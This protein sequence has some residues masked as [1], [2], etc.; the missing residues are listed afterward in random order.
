[1]MRLF[2]S[3]LLFLLL[4]QFSIIG[5]GAEAQP[6]LVNPKFQ[7]ERIFAG[8][9]E[10]SSMAFLGPDDL[11]V[12]DR[13]EGKVFRVTNGTQIGPLL[14]VNVATNGYR[15]LL[16]VDI[17][18]TKNSTYVF[19]Y[20]TES[21]SK[22]SSDKDQPPIE[23]LGNR[24]YR[25]ELVNDKLVNPKLLLDLPVL[26]GPKDN[27]GVLKIGPDNNVYLIIG[28][29]QGSFA[30]EHYETMAQNYQNS[31]HVD[32][33]AGILVVSQ[34]G[35]SMGKGILGSSFP[36][37]LYYA[38]GIRNSFGMDWDPETGYLW[39]SEN[40][41]A[42]GDELNLVFSGFNSGWAQVQGIWKPISQ[43]IGP[44]DSS[45]NLVNFSGRGNYSAPKFIWLT[46]TAPSAIKFINS[47]RYGLDYENDLLV[48]DVNN[49][50]IYHFKLDGRR[51]NLILNGNLS[52]RIANDTSE[53][54]D[55]IFARGFGKVTG[56]EI[57][58]DG[59]LYILSGQKHVTGIYRINAP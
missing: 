2:I 58:P 21:D 46:P 16:G 25:Y 52:D 27:G 45:P 20:F 8:Q 4:P 51:Q 1:M 19:L 35:K 26:P 55:V 34:D 39:D 11:L 41:P 44:V 9:F 12:L 17:S 56:I 50:N 33:R 38:Y 37:N 47:S 5:I 13:D 14:D 15:G 49:G 24:L 22:D 59:L 43:S 36:L 29:L 31:T 57:G 32:G 3:A 42:F 40:G 28:D 7:P 30:N 18:V 53:L 10:P 6:V 23:P 54:K 48:G